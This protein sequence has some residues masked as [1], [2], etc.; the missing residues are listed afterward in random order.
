[1]Y[2]VRANEIFPDGPEFTFFTRESLSIDPVK[3]DAVIIEKK[4]YKSQLFYQGDKKFML[5]PGDDMAATLFD[6]I[7]NQTRNLID[8]SNT[9]EFYRKRTERY[10]DAGFW[11]RVYYLFTSTLPAPKS[12]GGK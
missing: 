3:T 10:M 6:V 7:K 9:A 12:E 11:Q 1:M 4:S 5:A 2:I 8:V